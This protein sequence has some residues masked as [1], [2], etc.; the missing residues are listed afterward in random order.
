LKKRLEEEMDY[1]REEIDEEY[2]L[3]QVENSD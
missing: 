2:K 1:L 3:M